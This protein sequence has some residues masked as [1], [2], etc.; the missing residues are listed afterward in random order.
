MVSRKLSKDEQSKKTGE[1]KTA[2]IDYRK[3]SN[4]D[5]H[6]ILCATNPEMSSFPVTDE[7]RETVIAMLEIAGPE[8]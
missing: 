6:R 5:L 8:R 4:E 3:L 2:G 1:G 7:T